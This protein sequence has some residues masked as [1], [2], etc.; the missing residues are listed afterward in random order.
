MPT[1]R[2]GIVV[3]RANNWF[4]CDAEDEREA[5][6]P[7]EKAKEFGA[8]LI[9]DATVEYTRR[10]AG[11][12]TSGLIVGELRAEG[13]IALLPNPD[14]GPAP[15]GFV[16]PYNFIPLTGAVH[17]A[18][19]ASHEYFRGYS[20]RIIC[21]LRTLTPFF[22]PDAIP[23]NPVPNPD[24]HETLKLLRDTTGRCLI[25]SSALKGMIR[26]IAEAFS[27][28]CLSVIDLDARFSWRDLKS[29]KW[30]GYWENRE[31]GIV[32]KMPD[33]DKPG[34]IA[35]AAAARVHFAELPAGAGDSDDATAA[36]FEDDP[37]SRLKQA[38]GV[39]IGL[40]K[41][42]VSG[43]L[44]I[45]EI[46]EKDTKR[47]T[48]RF[49]Y[50]VE[51]D[52]ERWFSFD[53]NVAREYDSAT[54]AARDLDVRRPKIF[55]PPDFIFTS[56]DP[57]NPARGLRRKRHRLREGDIVYFVPV[58]KKSNEIARLGPVEA[59]RVMYESGVREGVPEEFRPC[60]HPERLCA[61]CRLFGWIPPSRRE[62]G[63]A[64]E[65][66]RAGFVSFSPALTEKPLTAADI[67]EAQ[68]TLRPLGQPHAS[69]TIFYLQHPDDAKQTGRYD[70]P[71]Y[72]ARGRKFYWHREEKHYK[73][74]REDGQPK[75]DNQNKTVELLKADR[76]FHFSISF[77][78]LS[79]AQLGLLL[80]AVQPSLLGAHEFRHKIG[81]GKPLGLGSAE[82]RVVQVE[83]IR[84]EERY[85]SLWATGIEKPKN[86][87]PWMG[88][89]VDAF[90]REALR[91]Q[92]KTA[93]YADP[94]AARQEFARLPHVEPLLW[95]LEWRRKPT[96]VRYPPGP[97][98]AEEESFRWF[99]QFKN[100]EEGRLRTVKE[101]IGAGEK[102]A[103][104]PPYPE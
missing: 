88:A 104:Q 8:E 31:I 30:R 9:A 92:G 64:D 37:N 74:A 71:P 53:E 77:E 58:S 34:W 95:M 1:Y 16:N 46:P 96:D 59:S 41:T 24:G 12:N 80:V 67:E 84:R 72:K 6:V 68:A 27:N 60:S 83:L 17:R 103:R 42:G 39:S 23:A 40:A 11:G 101:I 66:S 61:C 20:G 35:P 19:P 38:V 44:K 49:I 25:P 7:D 78:N 57:D 13:G 81:L 26:A 33:G 85:S 99:M 76:T 48:Q 73:D 45:T 54:E 62:R 28:S 50:D 79:A 21:S 18:A 87:R 10:P 22:T 97:K 65:E 93:A 90:V 29:R 5:R 94:A 43:Q 4:V 51:L 47:K 75:R 36:S 15:P 69:A 2:K 98:G 100:R 32:E 91:E 82:A 89:F 63:R 70:K 55:S 86:V 3:R 56:A 52:P 14:G 102:T